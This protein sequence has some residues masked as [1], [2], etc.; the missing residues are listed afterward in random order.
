MST[1]RFQKGDS[2]AILTLGGNDYIALCPPD[3]SDPY[4]L[5]PGANKVEPGVELYTCDD[6]DSA[7]VD[8]N[9]YIRDNANINYHL[10]IGP[11]PRNIFRR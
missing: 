6:D 3:P 11:R 7:Q 4:T 8:V 1:I 10:M 2:L 5:F 9:E